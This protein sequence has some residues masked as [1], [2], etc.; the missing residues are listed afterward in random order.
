MSVD[1]DLHTDP[2]RALEIKK[3]EFEIAELARPVWRKPAFL[4]PVFAAILTI[5]VGQYTGWF[6]VQLTKLE[7]KKFE[8]QKEI[9]GF[10]AEKKRITD[11]NAS[12]RTQ[13]ADLETKIA[14]DQHRFGAELGGLRTFYEDQIARL[15]E[16][17]RQ[18]DIINDVRQQALAL[19][20]TLSG[21]RQDIES[22]EERIKDEIRKNYDVDEDGC[23]SIPGEGTHCLNF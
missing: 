3:L 10:Q 22:E 21:T 15:E 8:L 20:E 6:N 18:P 7:N 2:K 17:L 19:K 11:E 23:F 14:S 9:D 12:L 1:G 16:F 13:L 4:T 5:L